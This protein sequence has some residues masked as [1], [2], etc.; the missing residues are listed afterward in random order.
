MPETIGIILFIWLILLGLAWGGVLLARLNR[1]DTPDRSDIPLRSTSRR[2]L[3]VYQASVATPKM[4]QVVDM[5][6]YKLERSGYEVQRMFAASYAD[7]VNLPPFDVI[8]F[9]TLSPSGSV[10][11]RLWQ[12]LAA[13]R[14]PQARREFFCLIPGQPF[15][16]RPA[17]PGKT[18]QSEGHVFYYDDSQLDNRV[19]RWLTQVLDQAA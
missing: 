14:Q 4:E 8:M 13:L 10:S 2:A 17:G 19:S 15:S 1:T 16:D 7:M 12:H 5:L 18:D 3:I 9:G 6:A 11:E